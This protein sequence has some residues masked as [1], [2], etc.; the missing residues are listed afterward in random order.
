ML[1]TSQHGLSSRHCSVLHNLL[2]VYLS[3]YSIWQMSA[4]P[5]ADLD[6]YWGCFSHLHP[7]YLLLIL[8]CLIGKFGKSSLR[9][10]SPTQL[11]SQGNSLM[12]ICERCLVPWN[13]RTSSSSVN[14]SRK[15]N[16]AR[17]LGLGEIYHKCVLITCFVNRLASVTINI[18]SAVTV[19]G[20]FFLGRAVMWGFFITLWRNNLTFGVAAG[21]CPSKE[22]LFVG[23]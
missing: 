9:C 11:S 5:A 14:Q 22:H 17:P 3:S 1:L 4:L 18:H 12:K 20:T 13:C 2:F 16:N 15:K 23:E 6:M 10:G 19:T 8:T 7:W 21:E